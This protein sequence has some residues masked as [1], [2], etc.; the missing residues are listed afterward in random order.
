M[1]S[2]KTL[3]SGSAEF[4]RSHLTDRLLAENYEV[5]GV[6]NFNNYYDPRTKERNLES[7]LKSKSFK[8][9]KTDIL[10]FKS[11]SNIFQKERAQKILGWKPIVPLEEGLR[12]T[13]NYFKII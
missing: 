5:I 7:A 10:D 3:I 9:Y 2:Y 12:K 11:L 4:I 6:D 8:L 1:K 13:I